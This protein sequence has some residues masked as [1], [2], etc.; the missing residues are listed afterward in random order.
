MRGARRSPELDAA[1]RRAVEE[2]KQ[3][4]DMSAIVGRKRKVVKVGREMRALCAFHHEKS[5]SM[6][7][8][9]AKGIYFCFG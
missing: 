6:Y 7:L 9:D 1:W 5:P 8:N 3:R 2:A 4:Y